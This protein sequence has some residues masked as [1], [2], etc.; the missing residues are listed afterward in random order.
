LDR[1]A[2]TV[3]RY[4]RIEAGARLL[5]L[6]EP[7]GTNEVLLARDDFH[8]TYVYG[9]ILINDHLSY[10]GGCATLFHYG[11]DMVHAFSRRGTLYFYNNTV[12]INRRTKPRIYWSNNLFEA[13]HEDAK[14]RL[15]N[16][17]FYA[18]PVENTQDVNIINDKGEVHT[19]GGNWINEGWHPHK[20]GDPPSGIY[21]E[22]ILDEPFIEGT[23]AGIADF[24]IG[25]FSLLTSS[26]ARNI[27]VPLPP[28]ITADYPVLYQYRNGI[29]FHPRA[30]H[31][32]SGAV[33]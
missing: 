30:S 24:A 17:I 1:S 33:E 11:Q 8:V 19:E 20:S 5:D 13:E 23:D 31:Y 18:V 6:V 4:K 16:N 27:A 14:I 32:H 28:E 12:Y 25:D 2:G 15:F 22:I 21:G 26:P 29:V 9:N 3:I 7:D 10:N